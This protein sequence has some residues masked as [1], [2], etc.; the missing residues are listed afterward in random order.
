MRAPAV[1]VVDGD[2]PL[3]ISKEVKVREKSELHHLFPLQGAMR[4]IH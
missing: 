3:W 4:R 1:G 2:I